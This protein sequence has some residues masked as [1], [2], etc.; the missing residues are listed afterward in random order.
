MDATGL[1]ER[2]VGTGSGVEEG[3]DKQ[4][5]EQLHAETSVVDVINEEGCH[6]VADEGNAGVEQCPEKVGQQGGTAGGQ[7]ANEG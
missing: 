5:S 1:G 3:C 7:N 6:P 2:D 4:E